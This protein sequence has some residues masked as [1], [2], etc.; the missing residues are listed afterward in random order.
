V[1]ATKIPEAIH[2]PWELSLTRPRSDSHGA[3]LTL[4]ASEDIH[5]NGHGGPA[6][7]TDK[8]ELRRLLRARRARFLAAL[9]EG[10]RAAANRTLADQVVRH[11]GD[12]RI[13]AGYVAIGGECDPAAILAAAAAGT[14]IALPH[15][16][17]P[18]LPMRFLAWQP[19]DPLLAGPSGLL[20]PA[21]DRDAVEPD[22]MLVPLIGFDRRLHRLGQGAGYYD[23]AC[24][25]LPDA[26]RIGLGW[27][28]QEVPALPCDPWDVPLHA[29]ATERAWIE[30]S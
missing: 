4:P 21:A 26:R 10:E 18:A 12:A 29:V 2:H 22:V 14:A 19:G 27:S 28:V 11:I 1:R 30:P 3:H 24:A 20:Q 17:D 25:L 9:S 16:V 6:N 7:P 13:L 5:A 8:P 23:R 15:V